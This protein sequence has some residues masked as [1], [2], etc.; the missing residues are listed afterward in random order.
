MKGPAVRGAALSALQEELAV[1]GEGLARARA[2][3]RVAAARAKGEH[4]RLRAAHSRWTAVGTAAHLRPG[5]DGR[6]WPHGKEQG[7]WTP[8]GTR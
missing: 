1:G 4:P 5:R 2:A 6:W 7:C 3:L 8:T